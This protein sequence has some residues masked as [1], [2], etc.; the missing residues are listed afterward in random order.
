MT[1]QIQPQW[2]LDDALD[3]F[4]GIDAESRIV[5]WNVQAAA[6][7]GWSA[8]EA[9]GRMLWDTIIPPAY[10]DA[11]QRGM[12]RFRKTGQA[13]VVSQRLELS[14]L[15]RDGREFPVEITISGPIRN[16]TSYFFGAFLRDISQRKNREEELHRA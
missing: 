4:I 7:F 2:E 9:I 14:A 3:A 15:H 13:P 12:E 1:G 16:T 10:R 8:E 6:T 5:A 11:H